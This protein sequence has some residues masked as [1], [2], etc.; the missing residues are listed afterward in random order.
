MPSFNKCK[1]NVMLL[2]RFLKE[3]LSLGME[4]EDDGAEE[5]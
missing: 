3:E 1:L 2:K 5:S 4:E